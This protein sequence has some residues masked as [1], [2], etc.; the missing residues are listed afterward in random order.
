MWENFTTYFNTYYNAT[1]EY[2]TAME[3]IEESETE[4]FAFKVPDIPN[5]A[6]AALDKVI[7]KG[8]SIMQ[9]NIE[10]AYFDDALLMVGVS[11]YYQKNY[12]KALRKFEELKGVPNSDL[13]TENKLWIARSQMQLRQFESSINLIDEVIREAKEQENKQLQF[14]AFKTQIS[15]YMLQEN[16]E[17]SVSLITQL[18][19]VTESESDKAEIA[20]ELGK[21][22]KIIG[23]YESAADAFYNANKY[24]PE[25][26]ILFGSQLE[27]AKSK[28]ELAE[29]DTA[30]T[31]LQDLREEDKYQQYYDQIELQKGLVYYAQDRIDT[32]KGIF[33]MIDSTFNDGEAKGIAN[34]MI[35][36]IWD[37]Y[38]NVYDSA[39]TYYN[40]SIKFN[41]TADLKQRT[42]DRIGL[43]KDYL[44][45]R[46]RINDFEK[47]YMY[48]TD[49]SVFVQDSLKYE[50]FI[51]RVDSAKNVKA[52][53]EELIGK[54]SDDK[55]K[56]NK[57]NRAIGERNI[58]EEIGDVNTG[59]NSSRTSSFNVADELLREFNIERVTQ[60]V[61][62]KIPADTIASKLA[63]S[64]YELANFFFIEFNNSDSAIYHYE[65]I[66]NKYPDSKIKPQTLYA[67]GSLYASK[68]NN[69]KA[70]SLY[71][72]LYDNYTGL[73]IAMQ[74]GEKLGLQQKSSG[75]TNPAESEYLEAEIMYENSDFKS[76]I[77]KLINL[78]RNYPESPFAPK[79]LYTIGWIYETEFNLKDS[80]AVYYYDLDSTF[81]ETRYAAAVK[82][83][84]NAYRREQEKIQ[85]A[86]QDSL[87]A[88][89]AEK[90]A[91]QA[92]ADSLR[93][94]DSEQ[95]SEDTVQT[96]P[97]SKIENNLTETPKKEI[98]KSD[99][100]AALLN[101]KI[102]STEIKK[103]DLILRE[104]ELRRGK[105]DST[106]TL[107]DSTR[108]EI[109]EIK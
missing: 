4:M 5:N 41:I 73:E 92:E 93:N 12:A 57:D 89:E 25:F 20:Y 83:K 36:E 68:K 6:K 16:Y 48:V 86:I 87:A 39:L 7:K 78:K 61:M 88:I 55:D 66:L 107:P 21:L 102:D 67:L 65:E 97:E 31:I 23:D 43:L 34:F 27:L 60:P 18:L 95:L 49:N 47:K 81:S 96:E 105:I 85:K 1:K 10:S 82:N 80:A 98:S 33:T 69:T 32:A 29:Y 101:S 70:D 44:K 76:A 109:P 104:S 59:S 79:A 54:N 14:E 26:E 3:L 45:L 71:R 75:E 63:E 35:G 94:A 9:H 22:Y 99:S 72:L 84:I 19:D 100:L 15:Y 56:S 46:G 2:N 108:K 24:D 90:L 91:A 58:E 62:P 28:K 50:R 11:F 77:D 103:R 52:E 40:K 53:Q 30:L 51:T 38:D 13:S 17:T 64:K 42:N 106:K 37:I 74:A 8:S